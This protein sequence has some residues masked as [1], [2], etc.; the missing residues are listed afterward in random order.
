[1]KKSIF[2]AFIF[3]GLMALSCSD[4]DTQTSSPNAVAFVNSS[5]NLAADETTVNLVFQNPTTAA[6]T[7]TLAVS[8]T[9]T[10]YG[11]DFTTV[12]STESNVLEVPFVANVTTASFT[13]NRLVEAL[14]EQVKNATFT[15]T[16]V[17]LSTI[18][19]PATTK[20]IQ[21]NFDESPITSAIKSPNAGGPT[22]PNQVYFDFSS[23]I[24]TPV[25]RTKWDLGFFSGNEFRVA[26]NGSL[27]MAVKNTETTDMT[28]PV[29]IDNTVAVGEGG[30]SGVSNGNPAYVDGPNGDITL[31]AIQSV[32]AN[33][34]DNKVYLVNLGYG[35]TNV[36]PNVG[37]VNPYGDARGWKKIRVLRSGSDYK[38]QYANP[39]ATTFSEVTISKNSAY[40]FTFFSLTTNQVVTAEPQKDKWDILFTPFTNTTNFGG[41]LVSYAFQ[42]FIV[43]NRKGGTT[44]Y[45]VLNSEGV[46][47]ANFTLANVVTT[48][49]TLDTSIDQRVIGSNWRN[50]GGPSS[51]PSVRDDRFYVVKDIAGNI[52]KVRFVAMTNAAG[53]RGFP[54]VEY[55]LLN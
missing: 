4:D 45:Q 20:T 37:S 29:A 14:E 17:S 51:L 55:Q 1:M 34:A 33:D 30:G 24:D 54:T 22:V 49:F 42:D 25:E 21:L 32:S 28:L 6:G 10:A 46:L 18:E 48:N 43:T 16:A 36:A 5:V 15:I 47:Y 40:N 9:N 2:S 19:I 7:I 53:E 27:K 38:L 23:G 13:F 50:G 41:G 12:P 52:Y 26:I 39:E 8:G 31:T 35:L 11:V 44:A 3:L